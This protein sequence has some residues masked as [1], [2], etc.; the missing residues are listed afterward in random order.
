MTTMVPWYDYRGTMV[1]PCRG[2]FILV[3]VDKSSE[4]DEWLRKSGSRVKS[5][6][7]LQAQ[8]TSVCF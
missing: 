4:V 1:E 8:L 5:F 6:V 7:Y 3:N 2:T